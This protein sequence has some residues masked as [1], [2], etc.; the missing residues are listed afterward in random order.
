[1]CFCFLSSGFIIDL[2]V[3]D[4]GADANIHSTWLWKDDPLDGEEFWHDSQCEGEDSWQG[5]DPS[6]PTTSDVCR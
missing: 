6:A 4:C 1:M 2:F 3:G 5:N